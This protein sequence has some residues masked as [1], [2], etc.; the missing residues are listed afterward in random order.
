MD[1]E[2]YID[3][4]EMY[5]H[6]RFYFSNGSGREIQSVRKIKARG[7]HNAVRKFSEDFLEWDEPV[8]KW[9][10]MNISCD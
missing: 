9:D 8:P 2:E 7:I 1:D 5:F 10:L 4:P 6:F 3:I